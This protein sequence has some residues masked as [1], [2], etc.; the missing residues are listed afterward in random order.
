M[1]P[2]ANTPY[3]RNFRVNGRGI[4]SRLGFYQFGDD[5]GAAD[6][7]RGIASYYRSVIAND[8]IVVRYNVDGTHK[9]VTVDPTSAA[10]VSVSTGANI[11]SDNRMNFISANDSLYCMN[12]SDQM[13]KLNGTT[14]T[15]PSLGI[16]LRPSF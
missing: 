14:Y 7:P 1:I 11:A 16:T 3:A 5:L 10:Q 6:Y 9:L 4:S 12:G 15:V 8:R 2:Y 13:G